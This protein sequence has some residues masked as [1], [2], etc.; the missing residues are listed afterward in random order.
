MADVLGKPVTRRKRRQKQMSTRMMIVWGMLGTF[1]FIT[2]IIGLSFIIAAG[3]GRDLPATDAL[4][5]I[6]KI[7]GQI[8]GQ[9]AGSE[10]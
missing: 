7:A 4:L 5:E 6:A 2:F 3:Q 1:V 10:E 8:L 9:A